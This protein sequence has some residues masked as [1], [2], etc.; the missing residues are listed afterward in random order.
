M[1]VCFDFRMPNKQHTRILTSQIE[2]TIFKFDVFHLSLTDAVNVTLIEVSC[3]VVVAPEN[4]A[5]T[6]KTTTQCKNCSIYQRNVTIGNKNNITN[7]QNDSIICTS[8]KTWEDFVNNNKT[9]NVNR[10]AIS[11]NHSRF[12]NWKDRTDTYSTMFWVNETVFYYINK[13]INCTCHVKNIEQQEEN[14]SQCLTSEWKDEFKVLAI[15]SNWTVAFEYHLTEKL[16]TK[17][18]HQLEMNTDQ[19]NGEFIYVLKMALLHGREAAQCNVMWC[20]YIAH[21]AM[22]YT[23]YDIKALSTLKLN[24]AKIAR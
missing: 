13:T 18:E 3:E 7:K 12:C 6:N 20:L 24:S 21:F 22:Y 5:R 19:S 11:T 17:E 10:D 16:E 4:T 8:N 9:W 2:K 1:Y 14:L 15:E 23:T